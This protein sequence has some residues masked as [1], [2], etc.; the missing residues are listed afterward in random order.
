M[1]RPLTVEEI[2]ATPFFSSPYQNARIP[3]DKRQPVVEDLIRCYQNKFGEEWFQSLRKNL[4]PSPIKEIAE[5]QG[6]SQRAVRHMKFILWVIG[7][8]AT[9]IAEGEIPPLH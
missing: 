5:R 3:N 6:V 9:A 4:R 1:D 8:L 7:G 2:Y